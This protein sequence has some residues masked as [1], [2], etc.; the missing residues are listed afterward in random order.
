MLFLWIASFV[1]H[2]L[3]DVGSDFERRT[4][5]LFYVLMIGFWSAVQ[6]DALR[7]KVDELGRKLKSAQT[8]CVQ[9]HVRLPHPVARYRG[10]KEDAE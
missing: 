3:A 2:A 4:E 10:S 6:L 7:D 1:A 8:Y 9:Q 5:V